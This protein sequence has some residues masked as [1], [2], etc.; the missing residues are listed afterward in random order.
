MSKKRNKKDKPIVE[1]G[2]FCGICQLEANK[3]KEPK[4]KGQ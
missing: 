4:H 2:K 1:E 3:C